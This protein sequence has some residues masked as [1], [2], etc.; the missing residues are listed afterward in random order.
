MSLIQMY[1]WSS[2]NAFLNGTS[3]LLLACGFCFIRAGNIKCHR[4]CMGSAF[5]TSTIFLISYLA[6]HAHVGHVHFKTPGTLRTV[7]YAI[8]LS[9][10]LLAIVIVP[11]ILRTLF[12]ALNSRFTEHKHWARWTL[13]LWFYVSVTGVVVYVLLYGLGNAGT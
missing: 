7:Y 11:L 12:L 4:F 3:A 6:Y 2:V 5:I 10:T 13:P 8:L 9:H 1:P